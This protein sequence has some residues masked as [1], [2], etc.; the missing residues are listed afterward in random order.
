MALMPRR[1]KYRKSHRGRIRGRATRSNTV[2]FGEFGLQSLDAG[3]I[4]AKTIEAGRIV[5]SQFVRGEGRVYIRIFPHS[6]R[7]S[8]PPE[9][10]MGKGKGEPQYWVAVVKPGT[11]L[12][13]ISG[14]PEETARAC[15]ARIAHKMPVRCRMV[16]RRPTL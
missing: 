1:V 9:T 14:I 5:A 12:Y 3:Q 8:R 4:N 16:K 6:S 2:E 10:R 15:F 11:I 13:E 7:T